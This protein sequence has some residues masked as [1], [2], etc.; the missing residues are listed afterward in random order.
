MRVVERVRGV[1][2][3]REVTEHRESSLVLDQSFQSCRQKKTL[4]LA[5]VLLNVLYNM[6]H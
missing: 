5:T 1:G 2:L 6:K 3:V 4:Q